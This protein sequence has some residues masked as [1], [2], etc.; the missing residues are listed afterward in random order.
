MATL[1][2]QM[3]DLLSPDDI[4]L[5]SPDDMM[6]Q[7]M[8]QGTLKQA[9][10]NTKEFVKSVVKGSATAPVMAPVDVVDLG[11]MAPALKDE[12]KPFFP[13]YSGIEE[14]FEQLSALGFSR[15]NATKW[16]ADNTGIQL[17]GDYGEVVGEFI[18][19]AA[20]TN[21]AVKGLKTL[22]SVATKYG[23]DV[24]FTISR[25]EDEAKK[26]FNTASGGDDLDGMAPAVAG[27]V[28]TPTSAADTAELPDTSTTKMMVGEKGS[29][30]EDAI[31]RYERLKNEDPDLT[32]EELY[33]QTGVYMGRD[34][35]PRAELD[36]QEAVL[37]GRSHPLMSG[38]DSFDTLAGLDRRSI[39]DNKNLRVEALEDGDVIELQ[40]IVDFPSLFN[41]YS[42]VEAPIQNIYSNK[43]FGADYDPIQNIQINIENIN[44]SDS[45][46]YYSPESD[47]ITISSDLVDKPEEFL[48]VLLHEVQHAVQ[49][50]EGFSGGSNVAMFYKRA[51]FELDYDDLELDSAAAWD[52]R[53]NKASVRSGSGLQNASRNFKQNSPVFKKDQTEAG[54][55]D[56]PAT[57]MVMSL[58]DLFAKRMDN[59]SYKKDKV[60]SDKEKDAIFT[61]TDK[62]IDDIV[63]SEDFDELVSDHLK[64]R[65][66]KDLRNFQNAMGD[67]S[68][69][70][71]SVFKQM[72]DGEVEMKRL[73]QIKQRA[74]LNYERTYGELESRLVQERLG[75]RKK[76]AAEG[77]STQEIRDIMAEKYPPVD[78]AINQYAVM[79][80]DLDEGAKA[81]AEKLLV[82][83]LPEGMILPKEGYPSYA[84]GNRGM[85]QLRVKEDSPEILTDP[86]AYSGFNE[87]AAIAESA[88][89]PRKGYDP[90]D[91]TSRVFHLTKKDFDVAD[92]IRSGTDD[93]GFHVGTAAQA[94]ARGSTGK[95]Y[96]GELMEAMTK[97]ERILPMV[98][99]QN[100]KPARIPDMSSF[101]EPRNWLGNLS[102]STSDL[103]GMKF[104]KGD[105]EDAKLLENAPRVT[106]DGETR[107]MMPDAIR[108]GVDPDLWKDLILEAS[109]ARRIGLDTINKQEDRV[110]WFNTL[111]ATANKHGYDS[112]VY[113]N[114][115]E[116][117]DDF[118]VDALV[119][120]IQ[121][122]SRGEI[123]PSEVDVNTRFA[124]SYM[125]LEPDQAKGIF[126]AMTEGNPEFM[127]NRGGLI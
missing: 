122:A 70:L 112:F 52:S 102:I 10:E 24:P 48:S 4:E 92:V 32:K 82:G 14:A 53:F 80:P 65:V 84:A 57:L 100:L 11:V 86:D 77:Y 9:Q 18:S 50:R 109:R 60:Y 121:R 59:D 67:N 56:D 29:V 123:D 114:E 105:P 117:S 42:D 90:T 76:L 17:K 43:P 87:S 73:M 95:P 63:K 78:M 124:D 26:L 110:E 49:H 68:A 47:T 111:K 118:N 94:T 89:A 58:R 72:A 81:I 116:G 91:E 55:F 40:E 1:N 107:I 64:A 22:A 126:G 106:V 20:A 38:S 36:T 15:K 125:L 115:Y 120:Q 19:P 6:L 75:M 35:M 27:D 66:E 5:F 108:A 28:P 44:R 93:I 25:I 12:V 33:A 46:A 104:L 39:P 23:N 2:Q 71:H 62:D 16:L 51:G 41:Q 45:V 127:K 34:G 98:L 99:K 97:G 85:G 37:I 13:T 21:T 96:D 79:D 31:F 88:P 69:G 54:E 8:E 30:G 103:Q 3:E 7:G 119:E 113:R 101:K 74:R 61:L 83:D